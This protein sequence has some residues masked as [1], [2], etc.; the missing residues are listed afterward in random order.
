MKPMKRIFAIL[1]FCVIGITASA[2]TSPIT[3]GIK[4]G[5]NDTKINVREAKV[6]SKGGYMLGAF[7]RFN[8]GKLYIE[9]GLNFSNKKSY[10]KDSNNELKYRSVDIPV[11]VGYYL[12]KAPAFNFRGFAGPVASFTTRRL[13]KNFLRDT[14]KTMWNGRVGVGIDLWKITFDVDYEF[15][16][17]RFGDGAKA[18]HCWNLTVGFKLF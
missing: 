5:W 6:E 3:I 9:P 4:A 16:F 12:F 8:L 18:P 7:A 17:R 15:G 14:D 2:Q 11:M 1:A 10:L 13:N